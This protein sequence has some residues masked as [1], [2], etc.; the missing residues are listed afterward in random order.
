MTSICV[1]EQF[2]RFVVHYDA[3]YT[4]CHIVNL[5]KYAV[6]TISRIALPNS[7]DFGYRSFCDSFD[8]GSVITV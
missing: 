1:V 4:P 2:R 7:S 5:G 3:T 8:P 6:G